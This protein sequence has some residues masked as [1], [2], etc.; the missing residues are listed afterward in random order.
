[1]E[2]EN[3]NSTKTGH[4]LIPSLADAIFALFF[5]CTACIN[6]QRLL[7]DCDTGY[8]IRAGEYIIR[9]LSVPRHDM[10]SFIS[11][12]LPWTAHEWLSEVIMAVLHSQFGLPGVVVFFSGLIALVYYLLFR[13]LRRLNGS[14]LVAVAL[15]LLAITASSLHWLARP[16]IFSLLLMVVWYDLL[17]RYQYRGVNRLYL[18][19]PMMLLWVNLHG[20]FIAGFVMLGIYGAGNLVLSRCG[21][22]TDRE[23]ARRRCWQI[24]KITLLCLAASL[25]NPFG[26]HIL[27]FPFHLVSDRYIMD[28]V[29]EFLSPNF[30][31][32]AVLPFKFMLLLLLALLAASRRRLNIIELALLLFFVNM[33]FYSV[34]Y[35]TLFAIIAAP[36]AARLADRLL[37]E[38]S[39]RAIDLLRRK[40]AGI[41]GI[42]SQARG[43]LWPLFAAL[44]VALFMSQGSNALRF[45]EKLKPVAAVEFMK[46]EQ[47]SGNMF[48]ND[49]F[50]D[51]IIYA[52][53]PQYR[54]FFDGRSDMYG[55]E[56]LK[57]YYK[58]ISFDSDWESVMK[59]YDMNWI[60]FDANSQLSR[61]LLGRGD[62]RL[63]YADKV[64][65]LFVRDIPLYQPLIRKY[66]D[67][68]PLL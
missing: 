21:A 24:V 53:W 34:R 29:I 13:T 3:I 14:I 67:V 59:K 17:D 6:G 15:I 35:I 41:A 25:A 33:A 56:K 28:H 66:P 57:E 16:H 55:T 48:N 30:H 18:F 7:G 50:G 32:T 38:G 54:V 12:A 51:Y 19:P 9:T 45:D 40:E 46:R 26:Y 5:F 1:M 47:I 23:A 44:A 61:Y 2:N 60:I 68:K 8:H 20:G 64:A 31:E 36:I 43:C 11:P 52:A 4:F 39:G 42:D 58:I 49:E 62:W 10:F 63:I 37:D 22:E 65:H 27:L